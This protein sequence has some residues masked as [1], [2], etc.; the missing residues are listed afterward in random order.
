M[1]EDEMED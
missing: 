1:F